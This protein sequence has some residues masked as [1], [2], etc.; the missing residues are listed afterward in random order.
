[1]SS[2]LKI[3]SVN[4]KIDKPS[5]IE[6]SYRDPV[7]EDLPHVVKFSGGR[8]SGMMLMKLLENN[9]LKPER[10]D[11]VVFNNTS[12]EHPKTYEFVSKCKEVCENEYKV[13]FFIVEHCTY[14]DAYHG[15]YIRMYTFRLANGKPHSKDN[16]NG[17]R[18]RG[19]I[20]EELLS[21]HGVVP[22]IFQRTCTIALKLQTTRN[23][24]KEWFLNKSET[25]RRGH[26]GNA[27]RID[28]KALYRRHKKNRGL[29]PEDVFLKKKHYVLD[30]PHYRN[31]QAWADYSSAYN[32]FENSQLDNKIFGDDVSFGEGSVEYVGLVGLRS[33]EKLRVQ[34]VLMKSGSSSDDYIGEKVYMPLHGAGYTSQDALNFWQQQG[35]NLEID[36]QEPLSNCTFCF[37]KGVENLRKVN[38][39][40]QN[41]PNECI[42]NTPCDINWWARIEERYSKDFIAEGK[43]ARTNIPDNLIGFF[44]A[45]SGYLYKYIASDKK[46]NDFEEDYPDGFIPCECTE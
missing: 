37:L 46:E 16:P 3:K 36:P 39:Y 45:K 6:I 10:G 21:W 9:I 25:K 40:F 22:S 43:T 26:F 24:L 23:F 12:A 32:K 30:Q 18:W 42:P 8:S 41:Q 15:E 7:H 31:C 35:W 27:S 28:P 14:E 44:G 33:D 29:V 19:E 11:V 20:F 13:P 17:Y 5:G 4:K 38:A 2:K 34:K 1:M